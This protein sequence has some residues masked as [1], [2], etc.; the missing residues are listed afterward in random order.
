MTDCTHLHQQEVFA[1][2]DYNRTDNTDCDTATPPSR[3]PK[4]VTGFLRIKKT[5]SEPLMA[6]Q[7]LK[8]VG[9]SQACGSYFFVLTEGG[10]KNPP[11]KMLEMWPS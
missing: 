8:I 2:P 10:V 11:V 6:R 5:L 4:S 9:Q 7:K 1:T 3:N